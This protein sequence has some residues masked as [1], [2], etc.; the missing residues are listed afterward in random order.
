MDLMDTS[1]ISSEIHGKENKLDKQTKKA[2]EVVIGI[3]LGTRNS[4]CSI[5]RNKKLEII[6]DNYGNNT[7]PSVVSFY[8]SI[9]LIGADAENLKEIN[10]KNTIYDV[11]RLIGC[12]FD[13]PNVKD[14]MNYFT[15]KIEEGNSKN[16]LISLDSVDMMGK[17]LYTPEEISA[18][19]LQKLKKN[20]ELYVGQR[21]DKA[22]ITV[23]AYFNDAQREATK[24]AA[25]IAGLD[26]LRMINEPTAA[27]LAYGLGKKK[28]HGKSEGNVIIYDLGAGTLDVSVINISG[29]VFKVLSVS[30]N[31]HLGGEDFDY[32]ILNHAIINF[33]SKNKILEDIDIPVISLKKLKN[34]CENA[35]KIL[36]S[37][38]RA[39]IIVDNFY[40]NTQLYFELTRDNFEA[41]CNDL[42]I[43]CI[44]PLK[45]ALDSANIFIGEIDDV[46]LVGGSSKIPYVQSM[47][48]AFFQSNKK[49]EF[50]NMSLNPDIVVS[51]GAAIYGY[52]LSHKEDP[53][54]ENMILLDVAPLS[55][56]VEVLK[57][58][59]CI[60][61]PRNSVL[62]IK[63]TKVFS[64]DTDGQTSVS[65]KVYEGERKLTKDNFL[66]GA[67][68]LS[69]F[70]SAPRG[71][72]RIR[73]T[74][75]ID[76]NGILQITAV[77]KNS[78]VHN[79]IRITS[80]WG[81]KGRLSQ[82]EIE[83]LVQQASKSEFEDTVYS[84]KVELLYMIEDICKTV[85]INLKEATLTETDQL[86][87][88]NDI[89][90]IFKWLEEQDV[91]K[92]NVD[93]LEEKIK[94]I[95]NIY[96]PLII[97]INTDN[98]KF[99]SKEDKSLGV[100]IHG[101]DPLESEAEAIQLV[102]SSDNDEIKKL[103]KNISEICEDIQNILNNPITI[104]EADD[105]QMLKD[106]IDTV[107]IWLYTNVFNTCAE[108]VAKIDE[109]NMMT[110]SIMDKYENKNIFSH[111]ISKREEL[112]LMCST[113]LTSLESDHFNLKNEQIDNLKLEVV[114]INNDIDSFPDEEIENKINI[115][116]N[117]CNE[118]YNSISYFTKLQEPIHDF[119]EDI[120]LDELIRKPIKIT[121]NIDDLI[122]TPLHSKDFEEEKNKDVM[123][124]IN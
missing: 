40:K 2:E 75:E 104:V 74:F 34:S 10:P 39:N 101:D 59:M 5:W 54:S 86:K 93:V 124:K 90:S 13:D 117:L 73:I 32:R 56:G 106:Y 47:L 61:I 122:N 66:V 31:T 63:R 30:G 1:T 118:Y 111:V 6:N 107:Y 42:F 55:L 103:K 95:K 119:E 41:M 100:Q 36:S 43:L 123:L 15:F 18:M 3:D 57:K 52:I 84:K 69:G 88:K 77:E 121:E 115:I 114:K 27:A 19:I 92:I 83:N 71:C 96:G 46:I 72:P 22:V 58:N 91:F 29:G 68:D 80:R 17:L 9:K 116:N 109:I 65:I 87:V 48:L 28:W 4:C 37:S 70:Q 44:K 25:K 102:Q 97:R 26:V 98:D 7:T 113:L 53:F 60:I 49:I 85:L 8:K 45:D 50:L 16:L 21:I 33:K 11:K 24:D 12:K 108:Y 110:K 38:D 67:F 20:A 76:L 120:D 99:K 62:P 81:A 64:T 51:A 94:S 89:R 78:D 82:D 14:N 105:I 112:I 23:P 79:T 35:K